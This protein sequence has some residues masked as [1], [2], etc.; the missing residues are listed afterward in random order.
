MAGPES[1]RHVTVMS[2]RCLMRP[3]LR[4]EVVHVKI[5]MK[6]RGSRLGPKIG[7]HQTGVSAPSLETR[8]ECLSMD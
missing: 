1:E 3:E 2:T 6:T 8:W 7:S 4:H 5:R